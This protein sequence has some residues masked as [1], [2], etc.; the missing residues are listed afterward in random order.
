VNAVIPSGVQTTLR[1]GSQEVVV[2][3]VGASLR[4]YTVEGLDVIEP[5]GVHE[6]APSSHGATLAPWPNRLRDGRYTFDGHDHQVPV[7]EPAT[8]SALHGLAAWARFSVAARETTAAHDAVDLA[9]DLVPTPGY[10]FPLR[11]VVRYELGDAGLR[12]TTDATNLGSVRAPYG[13]GFHP[14]LSTRGAAVDDCRLSVG[15]RTHVTV[16]D[17]LLPTGTEPSTGPH[18][19]LDGVELAGVSLDD[20]YVDVVRDA[21]GLSWAVLSAPDGRASALWMDEAFDA[22]QVCTGD[23]I[24]QRA[25]RRTSVAV[26]PM[27]CYADAFRTG[28]RL[29]V[30]EPG[31][32]H[33]AT[34]GL[35]LL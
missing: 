6:V 15:E 23:A 29:V 4:V 20:A 2:T 11:I 8:A 33:R 5:F 13:L 27:T 14:W 35:T 22:W 12:V 18:A 1:H 17:R 9:L 3:E 19:L 10:P 34:W 30:L 24:S 26:E 7:S 21:G 28:D 16:D 31:D 25:Y 32:R